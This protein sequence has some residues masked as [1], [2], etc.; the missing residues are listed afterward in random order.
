[1][2]SKKTLLVKF[3]IGAGIIFGSSFASM[4]SAQTVDEGVYTTLE[5]IIVTANRRAQSI[6]D[7]S[8]VVQS[9]SADQIREGAISEFRQ[10]QIAV[11]GLSIGVQDGNTEIFIRGVGSSNNTELGDPS[12]AP[13]LNGVYIPRPRGLGGF[14]YDLERVE[15][16]KGPQ[17]TL[18]GRNGLAGTLNI[19]TKRPDFEEVSGYAQL[20]FANRSGNDAEAAINIPLSDSSAVRIAGFTK[21]RDFGFNNVDGVAG[22]EPTGLQEDQGVRLSYLTEPTERTSLLVVADYGRESGTGYPGVNINEAQIETG[23][24]AEDLDLRDIRFRGRQG[25]VENEIFGIQAI[26]NHEFNGF[27]LEVIGSY[28]SVDYEQISAGNDGLAFAGQ[29]PLQEDNFS[30]QL[31]NTTSE[32]FIGEVRLKSNSDG[33]LEWTV[34]AFGFS[35][36]QEVLLYSVADRGFCCFSGLEFN[37]PDVNGESFALYGDVTYALNDRTRLLGGLRY[38]D[39]SKDRFGIGG[40]IALVNGGED[41]SCCLATRIGTEGFTPA[42]FD[43]RTNFDVSGIDTNQERAQFLLE[44]I[45]SQGARDDLITQLASVAAGL[46]ETG[47]CVARPDNDNGFVTCPEN[48]LFSF[49]NISIPAQQVGSVENDFVDFRIGIE[50]DLS[51]NHLLYAKLSTGTKASG[52]N[53]TFDGLAETFDSESIVSY[54]VGSRLSYTAFGRP[55]VFN[56]TAFYYDYDDQVFQ[57]LQCINFDMAENECN[58]FSLLNRNIGESELFGLELES[59]LHFANNLSLDV[60]ALFLDSEI[61]SGIVADSREQDFGNG[62]VTPFIDLAGNRLPRQSNFEVSTRLAQQFDLGAGSFDWQILAKYRSSFFLT[63]FNERDLNA[64]DGTVQTALEIGQATEQEGFATINVGLGYTFPDGKIR[65]EGYG[66]NITDVE[67]SLSQIGGAGVDVRFL[68]DARV[69]G[70]RAIANF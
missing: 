31:W 33:P 67:A 16:N 65:I 5:E 29:D 24:R 38:T 6:Q 35:E 42:G 8:G 55:A 59:K 7:V 54:E 13:H 27:D 61:K 21:D 56:A 47:E 40:G 30:G 10:L 51:E 68:N 9:L 36:D 70:V 50:H 17:G 15:I 25:E 39:E 58:G 43:G 14:F 12:A 44:G 2:K 53:D 26:L 22:L 1:M 57:D 64:L 63:Q 69:Y 49:Q 41:F 37:F 20:G 62:G 45:T 3:L 23:L 32:A 60:N 34:G 18:Y 46:T 11:P 19:I 4:V 66:Q 48:G 28:R 52:F